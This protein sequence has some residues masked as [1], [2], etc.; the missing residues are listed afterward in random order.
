[1]KFDMHFI[2]DLILAN[3]SH[4]LKAILKKV[5]KDSNSLGSKLHIPLCIT[6]SISTCIQINGN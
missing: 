5:I 4:R 6:Y 1:M 3:I 2:L